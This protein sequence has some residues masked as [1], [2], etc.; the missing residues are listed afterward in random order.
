MPFFGT[1]HIHGL[2]PC[3]LHLSEVQNKVQPTVSN[4]QGLKNELEAF[5]SP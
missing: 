1:V 3:Y 4:I 2:K 5:V